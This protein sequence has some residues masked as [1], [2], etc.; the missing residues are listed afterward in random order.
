MGVTTSAYAMDDH[1]DRTVGTQRRRGGRVMIMYLLLSLTRI[2]LVRCGRSQFSCSPF[3]V[4]QIVVK[5]IRSDGLIRNVIVKQQRG[6]L[7]AGLTPLTGATLH[8]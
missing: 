4:V 7:Q 2:E 8:D 3:E 5:D 1:W 6:G